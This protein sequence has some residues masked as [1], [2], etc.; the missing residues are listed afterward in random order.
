MQVLVGGWSFQLLLPQSQSKERSSEL[1]DVWEGSEPEQAKGCSLGAYSGWGLRLL[2]LEG[3]R[4]G[5]GGS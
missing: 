1:L 2:S 4:G 5:G 3:V